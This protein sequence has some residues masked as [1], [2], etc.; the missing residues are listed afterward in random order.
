MFAPNTFLIGAQK[1]GTTYLASRL[2]QSPDVSVCEP[3]EPQ[4]FTT[5]FETDRAVYEKSFANQAAKIT[6]D[7]STTYTFLRPKHALDIEGAPG[8]LQPVPERIRA[9]SPDAKFIYVMRDPV[10]RAISAFKHNVRSL[11]RPPEGEVSLIEAFEKDPMLELVGRYGDQ[12]ERYFESF[13]RE[14]FLFLRFEDLISDPETAIRSCA[15]FLGIDPGPVLAKEEAGDTH[16]AH[17]LSGA[18]RLLARAPG[19]K[20]G[21]RRMMPKGLRGALAERLLQ[22]PAPELSFPDK[23][24]AADRFAA[25][26]EKVRL[27]TGI[28]V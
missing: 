24:E 14:T 18:G 12:I 21:V 22:R 23:A 6:L 17:S 19:L 10:A 3:K 28:E 1:S 13:A 27:L 16:A 5:G 26:R 8:L 2:D 15:D 20:E 25:D 4:F 7:A 9:E 11:T